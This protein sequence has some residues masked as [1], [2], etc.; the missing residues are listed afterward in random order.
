MLTK[1]DYIKILSFYKKDIPETSQLIKEKAESILASKLCRCIK[2]IDPIYESK[3]IGICTKT[4]FTTKGLI[5][6]SFTCN[7][8]QR[9]SFRKKTQRKTQK[10]K[11]N[12]KK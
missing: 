12:K 7:A 1:K 11:K 5:R 10:N 4:I 8:K 6:G 2:K 3:S 9:V